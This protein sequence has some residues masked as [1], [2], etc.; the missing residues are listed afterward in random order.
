MC[1]LAGALVLLINFGLSFVFAMPV[2]SADPNAYRRMLSANLGE[3]LDW[4]LVD[5]AMADCR[6]SGCRPF[7][8]PAEYRVLPGNV[9]PVSN[10]PNSK[11]L[12]CNETGKWK[13][14][15]TDEYG[16]NG[17][18]P[19]RFVTSDVVLLGDSFGTGACLADRSPIAS[20]IAATGQTVLNLSIGGHQPLDEL[21]TL[22]EYAPHFKTLVWL[23]YEGND[24]IPA[25]DAEFVTQYL[26]PEF[27]QDLK[28]HGHDINALFDTLERDWNKRARL[29]TVVD[30][31]KRG[32][33]LATD[34]LERRNRFFSPTI[35]FLQSLRPAS[36]IPFDVDLFEATLREGKRFARSNGAERYLLV[37]LPSWERLNWRPRGH[38]EVRALD[39]LRKAASASAFNT[40]FELVDL[41]DRLYGENRD[42]LFPYGTRAHFTAFGY[43]IVSDQIVSK[44]Q[45]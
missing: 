40:G 14:I 8:N 2:T 4:R 29:R 21:G 36:P 38:A 34:V 43:S 31:P 44:L 20:G 12:Y 41:T 16:F 6:R 1:A 27:T 3:H 24:S 42:K 32:G 13:F 37:Y 25:A 33:N 22:K 39:R 7:I 18:S 26:K 9:H 30:K 45:D 17:N 19:E 15:L 10:R 28:S 11:V 23:F 35:S 5:E